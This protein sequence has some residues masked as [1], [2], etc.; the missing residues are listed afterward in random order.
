MK[1]ENR[2]LPL[3]G[4][5]G[6]AV[7]MVLAQHLWGWMNGW[8]GVDVFFVLSGFLIT[9]ILLKERELPAFWKVFYLRRFTR[10][11]PPF[12]LLLVLTT[13][14]GLVQWRV[15][16][17]YLLFASNF[18]VLKQ[19]HA[20][21]VSDLGILWSLAIEEQFYFVWPLQVRRFSRRTL[22]FVLTA[23]VLAEPLL[24]LPPTL[25]HK[26][27]TYTYFLTPFRLDG[28]AM[29]AL[30]ALAMQHEPSRTVLRGVSA[31]LTPVT[32]LALV[33]LL[34]RLRLGSDVPF[35]NLYGFSLIAINACILLAYVLLRP[36][37]ALARILSVW[38]LVWLGRISYGLYLYHRFTYNLLC[39]VPSLSRQPTWALPAEATGLSILFAWV[40]FQFYETPML[41]WGRRRV[42]SISEESVV[43]TA[44]FEEPTEA[45]S[46]PL[47]R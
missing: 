15:L 41:A 19:G 21:G 44:A 14:L 47:P 35:L 13:L 33:L 36:D 10:L 18:G 2:I 9:T 37:C 11:M 24:R 6:I 16:W 39:T 22:V 25:L 42:R 45:M 23:A 43:T 29:G 17:P 1:A 31:V 40:S 30:L 46:M 26:A 7:A 5:R 27:W 38:P 20:M 34:P 12:A 32:M 8:I 3:D 4:L 28:L